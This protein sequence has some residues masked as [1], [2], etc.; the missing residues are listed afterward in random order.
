MTDTLTQALIGA[1]YLEREGQT[2]CEAVREVVEELRRLQRKAAEETS[3][4][5]WYVNEL[6]NVEERLQPRA[7]AANQF[8]QY[9][10]VDVMQKLTSQ[11]IGMATILQWVRA[12][13][14]VA[15]EDGTFCIHCD[16]ASPQHADDCLLHIALQTIEGKL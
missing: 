15:H 6:H 12:A 2:T 9:L 7:R 11:K 13:S 4:A 1:D 8:C 16:Y 3:R 10:P 14:Q 5:N